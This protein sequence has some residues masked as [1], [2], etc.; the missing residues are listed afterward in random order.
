LDDGEED[1]ATWDLMGLASQRQAAANV[2]T[3]RQAAAEKS[4]SAAR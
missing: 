2:G 1:K 4:L 3:P